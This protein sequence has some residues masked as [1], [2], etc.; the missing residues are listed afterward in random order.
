MKSL[1]LLLLFISYS[2]L[3]AQ[4]ITV[5]G[6]VKDSANAPLA[7]ANVSLIEINKDTARTTTDNNGQF[8]FSKRASRN[9]T[10]IIDAF[11]MTTFKKQYAF[12]TESNIINIRNIVITPKNNALEDVTVTTNKAVY[13]REDTISYTADSFK[14]KPNAVVEDLLKKMP[15]L[16]VDRD[17]NLTAQGKSVT[18][19]KV[20]G[21]DF[22]NGDL[23]AA[24]RELPADII[25]RVDIIDDYGDQAAFT[26]IKDGEP[27]KVLN[28]QI[29][30]DK[31]NGFF[32]NIS[33]GKGTNSRYAGSLSAIINTKY[34]CHAL[35]PKGGFVF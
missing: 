2:G 16:E 14:V 26:G 9:F 32:G 4:N 7:G 11:S 17:G 18:R 35:T 31:N 21:K 19:V 12:E 25:D 34:S 23:K 33:A 1:L 15:G 13:I 28:L 8:I 3:F 27:Q 20:N 24:T 6:W 10:L 29:K 22:F 5:R 30:K